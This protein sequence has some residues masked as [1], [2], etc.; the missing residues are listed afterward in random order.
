[1]RYFQAFVFLAFLCAIG[2]FA[3]QNRN[4]IT[5]SFLNWDISQPVAILMVIV[6][7]LGMLS[8]WSVVAF[9]RTSYR[10]ATATPHQ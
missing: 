9:L 3:I 7:V 5:V 6:Y 8:G 4:V 2:V 10:G 1:M